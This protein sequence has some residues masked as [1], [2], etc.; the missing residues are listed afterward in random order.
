MPIVLGLEPSM[1]VW[2]MSSGYTLKFTQ[3]EF[4]C[5]ICW[6]RPLNLSRA[7]TKMTAF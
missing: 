1:H 4:F 7:E 2:C 3:V 6:L 5:E